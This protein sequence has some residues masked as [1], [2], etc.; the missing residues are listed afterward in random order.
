MRERQIFEPESITHALQANLV[1]G[2]RAIADAIERKEIDS[3]FIVCRPHGF[4]PMWDD[5]MHLVIQFGVAAKMVKDVDR[6]TLELPVAE[7]SRC[8]G[9]GEV[10]YSSTSYGACPD[11]G[12]Q[13]ELS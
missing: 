11:C 10:C 7:C 9:T 13:K 3:H 6:P 2:L 4:T 12:T 1:D 8:G 5:R